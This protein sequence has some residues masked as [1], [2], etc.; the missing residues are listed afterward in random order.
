MLLR[1]PVCARCKFSSFLLRE[2]E[3]ASGRIL[4]C[5]V[6]L[7]QGLALNWRHCAVYPHAGEMLEQLEESNPGRNLPTEEFTDIDS[8]GPRELSIEGAS[9]SEH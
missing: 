3:S 4:P 1:V 6:F 9:L 5:F 2:L 7:A 8:S